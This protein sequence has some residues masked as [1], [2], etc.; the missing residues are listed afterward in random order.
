[1]PKPPSSSSPPP[2]SKPTWLSQRHDIKR[3]IHQ[4]L[5]ETGRTPRLHDILDR[6]AA[7]GAT[8]TRQT[9]LRHVREMNESGE[10][11]GYHPNS[12]L[13]NFLRAL[14]MAAVEADGVS[15]PVDAA[16]R[17]GIAPWL[18]RIIVQQASQ[19]PVSASLPR[20]NASPESV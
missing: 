15:N 4:H 14:R 11:V 6:L 20:E 17:A 1:M 9:I 19:I 16:Q 5:C 12:R 8:T 10:L 7:E 3:V 13:E 2:P 18:C